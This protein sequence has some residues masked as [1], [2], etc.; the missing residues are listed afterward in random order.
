MRR[1]CTPRGTL[2]DSITCRHAR[3]AARCHCS[4]RLAAAAWQAVYCRGREI[5]AGR[6]GVHRDEGWTE[7]GVAHPMYHAAMSARRYG[8]T[9]A[10]YLAVHEWMD[11]T[12]S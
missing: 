1:L 6:D 2:P 10:D 7:D 12:K 8:G 3:V 9:T 5:G 4:A 11:Y